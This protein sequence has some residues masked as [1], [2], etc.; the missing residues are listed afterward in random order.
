M[1]D[2]L[3][4]LRAPLQMWSAPDG[5]L[6]GEGADGVYEGDTRVVSDLRLEPH[7]PEASAPPTLAR[8]L[9]RAAEGFGDRLPELFGGHA[10]TEVEPPLPYPASCRPQAWAAASAVPVA[11]AL[12]VV[13]IQ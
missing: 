13:P 5:E 2:R 11:Q 4:V 8:G 9:L 7:A 6:R 3:L 1:H 10:A 12:G